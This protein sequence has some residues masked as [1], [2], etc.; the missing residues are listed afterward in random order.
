MRILV[1]DDEES[2]RHMLSVILKKEGYEVS[3]CADAESALK[4]L[5]AE[6]FDFVLSDIR[7]PGLDGLDFLKA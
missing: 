7:M 4:V 1:I 2:I 5:E 6:E 3:V